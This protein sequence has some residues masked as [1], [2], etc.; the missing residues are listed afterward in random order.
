VV[1]ALV[2]RF[3]SFKVQGSTPHGCKQSLRA[4][5]LVKSQQFNQFRVWKLLRVRCMGP[6][7]T[8]QEWVRRALPWRGS[9]KKKKKKKKKK[10]DF[11]A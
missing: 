11:I 4:I 6:G 1:K 5:P 9:P 8:L 7:F 10:K 3:A 2:L